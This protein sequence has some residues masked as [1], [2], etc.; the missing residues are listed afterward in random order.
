MAQ[1]N[2]RMASTAGHFQL[3]IDGHDTPSYLNNVEGGLMKTGVV[4]EAVGAD[5]F[6]IK[7]SSAPKI[8]P[9]TVTFGFASAEPILK[10]IQASWRKNVTRRNGQVTHADFNL[11]PTYEHEFMGALI[12]ETIFPELDGASNKPAMIKVKFQAED[13]VSR[14]VK[15]QPQLKP[16]SNL[17]Q[18]A[19][20]CSGFRLQVDGVRGFEFANTLSSFTVKQGVRNFFVGDQRY[21]QAEP[22]RV[23]F[24]TVTGTL[25][26]GDDGKAIEAWYQE[27][28]ARG[29]SDWRAQRTGAL[30]FL[31]PDRTEVLF[32]VKF[33]GGLSSY[34][35]LPSQANAGEI[36]RRKFE[37]YFE[38]F[39]LDGGVLNTVGGIAGKIGMPMEPP[40]KII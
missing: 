39:D 2:Y 1:N 5:N 7:H 11:Y 37:M 20:L 35:M 31:A 17:N 25:A 30:E 21:S 29:M 14:S 26:E 18:K 3:D 8:D 36:K 19:W 12:T 6:K 33:E 4:S 40:I 16:F 24:P 38:K 13:V 34:D 10:W 9:F 23:E 28:V 27:S 32:R 15:G 22:T